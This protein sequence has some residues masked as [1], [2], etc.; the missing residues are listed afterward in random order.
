MGKKPTVVVA[1]YGTWAKAEKNPAAQI[2]AQLK[3]QSNKFCDLICLEIPVESRSL[4]TLLE[5]SL[6]KYRPDA[7]VGLGVSTNSGVIRP[8]MVGINWRHFNVPDISGSLLELIPVVESGPVAYQSDLPNANMVE[9]L[10]SAGIPSVISFHAGTHLCN[11]MLYTVRHLVETHRLH[12][13]SGFIHVPQTP[14]NVTSVDDP[15]AMGSSMSLSLM[16]QAISL[17]I[18]EIVADLTPPVTQAA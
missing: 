16:T 17:C 15:E 10:K 13:R 5:A 18:E 9:R 1:G 7:W 2:S 4:S 3:S 11:Q 8:E 12:T 6:M 14:Q